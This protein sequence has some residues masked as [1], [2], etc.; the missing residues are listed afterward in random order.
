MLT[1]NNVRKGV[2]L[3]TALLV[4]HACASLGLQPKT[5]NERLAAGYISVTSIRQLGTTLTRNNILSPDDADNVVKLSDNARSGLDVART[6]KGV[7][8]EDKLTSTLLILES[9][10]KYLATKGAK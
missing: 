7:E 9:L 6:L 4:L 8:A 1:L 10:Q 2:I 3:T 5:F